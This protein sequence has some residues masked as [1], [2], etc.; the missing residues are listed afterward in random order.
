MAITV[1]EAID[2]KKLQNWSESSTLN[3]SHKS[4]SCQS[5]RHDLDV[6]DQQPAFC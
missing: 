2:I 5:P 1:S 6:S 4:I 3:Y